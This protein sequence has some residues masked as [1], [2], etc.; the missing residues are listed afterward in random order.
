MNDLAD[1]WMMIHS[2][3]WEGGKNG[4]RRDCIEGNEGWEAWGGREK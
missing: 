4:G 1:K 3:G 2:R